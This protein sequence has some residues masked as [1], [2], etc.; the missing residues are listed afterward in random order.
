MI[1]WTGFITLPLIEQ[2]K[3]AGMTVIDLESHIDRLYGAQIKLE[4]RVARVS[5][6]RVYSWSAVLKPGKFALTAR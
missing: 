3:A 6:R 1:P 2:I 5:R 4:I